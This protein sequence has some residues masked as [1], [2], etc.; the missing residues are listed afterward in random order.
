MTSHPPLNIDV[1]GPSSA[2]LQ[3]SIQNA[4]ASR[5]WSTADD[6]VMAEYV[7]VMLAN[8]K[9]REQIDSELSDLVGGDYDAAFTDWLWG[10]ARRIMEGGAAESS[11]SSAPAEPS[12]GS[13]SAMKGG[14]EDADLSAR[15]GDRDEMARDARS[16]SPLARDLSARRSASPPA[17]GARRGD[18]WEPRQRRSPRR[19]EETQNDQRRQPR[20]LFGGASDRQRS[21]RGDRRQGGLAMDDPSLGNG[22]PAPTEPRQMRIRGVA[23]HENR[24]F[25][26][27]MQAATNQ[28]QQQHASQAPRELFQNGAGGGRGAGTSL[29]ARAGVP[30]P[31]AAVFTPYG[32]GE[33]VGS[34]TGDSSSSLFARMDPMIPN[35]APPADAA[36]EAAT[37]T[38]SGSF[39]TQ[40]SQTSL[41]RYSLSCTNPLCNYSHASPAAAL[42]RRG[43]PGSGADVSDPILTSDRPCRFGVDCTNKECGFSHVSPAVAFV[44][45]KQ[46]GAAAVAASTAT[47]TASAPGGTFANSNGPSSTP[48]R[49]AQACTNPSCPYAHFDA[50]GKPAPS[51]A[52]AKI[53][54]PQQQQQQQQQEGPSSS[55]N[56]SAAAANHNESDDVEI[57]LAGTSDSGGAA[58]QE[59][60]PDGKPLALDRALT[61]DTTGGRNGIEGNQG[62]AKPCKFGSG[63][64][65]SDCWFSHPEWRRAPTDTS[66]DPSSATADAGAGQVV[67]GGADR[68]KTH[69]S[70][71][72]S[73]FNTESG[74][75]MGEGDGEVERIIPTAAVQ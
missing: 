74:G 30:D 46:G 2:T 51:P 14:A 27:S 19:Y 72:L 13:D 68:G 45:M 48:C 67:S 6:P 12:A 54:N 63:C 10:E 52:L 7:L 17:R 64:I 59:K 42:A 24:S 61:S 44:R 15:E 21:Q 16:R 32:G 60:G 4:L 9:T 3:T 47:G 8:S 65:R 66:A 22:G 26:Q 28:Q 5:G 34:T 31:R 50:E 70:D 62:G 1:N 39:P 38:S 37:T 41:C 23:P 20:E 75:G 69:I 71:R 11:S 55:A 73:R 43:G 25:A 35:N 40:P 57:D 58:T 53:I 56:A 36:Q 18:H 49:F 29:L 33:T